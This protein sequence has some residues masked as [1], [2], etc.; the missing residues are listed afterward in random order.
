MNEPLHLPDREVHCWCLSLPSGSG[1]DAGVYQIVSPDELQRANSYRVDIDR[2]R[3]L[4]VRAA[5]RTLLGR[6][7][8]DPPAGFRFN[9]ND[10]GKPMLAGPASRSEVHFN[11][12]HSG[13]MALLAFVRCVPLGIDVE[14]ARMLPDLD[15]MAEVC[16]SDQQFEDYRRIPDVQER[17]SAFYRFWTRKESL[18][19]ALGTGLAQPLKEF[20]VTFQKHEPPALLRA[21]PD[22]GP[23]SDW[24]IRDVPVPAPWIAAISVHASDYAIRIMD[25]S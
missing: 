17:C 13:S 1:I 25:D 2:N 22:F 4:F 18:I 3:F 20:D 8:D 5:L 7:L 10:H 11:V 23:L 12:S 21:G 19:K 14:E 15:R 16:L 6:Y 9:T 24:T